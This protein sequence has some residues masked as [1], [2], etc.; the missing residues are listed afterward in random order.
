[1]HTHASENKDEVALVRTMTGKDNVIYLDT[2][3]MTGSDVV[4]AHCI[5][6][7]GE[8]ASVL[9]QTQTTVAHCPSS[10][11]KLASGIANIPNLLSRGIV[12]GLGADGAPCNNRMDMF[13]EMR[14]AALIQKPIH[15]PE[16]LPAATV[17]K[18]ATAQGSQ[19]LGLNS[20]SI[21]PGK[22]ADLVTI[23]QDQPLSWGGGDPCSAMVY[24]MTPACV[25]RVWIGGK[26]V[27]EDG[28]VCGW[29]THE[30]IAGCK[31]ALERVMKRAW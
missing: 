30:T 19:A 23:K 5:H 28:G 31:Q 2:L 21:A 1:M 27:V 3:G 22:L 11:L 20:G 17:F 8:E 6:L 18:M 15:G 4:L 29:N 9:A 12:C 14:L 7:T 16:A 25:D 10:N 26:L 13:T 24:A